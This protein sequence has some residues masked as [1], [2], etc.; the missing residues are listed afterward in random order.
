MLPMSHWWMPQACRPYARTI[1]S[2]DASPC[3]SSRR[4]SGPLRSKLDALGVGRPAGEEEVGGLPL[5][6]EA[7][8]QVLGALQQVERRAAVHRP[9]PD[10]RGEQRQGGQFQLRPGPPSAPPARP[11]AAAVRR[12]R[13]RTWPPRG[14]PRASARPRSGPDRRAGRPPTG[15]GRGARRRTRRP[16]SVRF[17]RVRDPQVQPGRPRAAAWSRRP[18]RGPGRARSGTRTGPRAWARAGRAPPAARGG[19]GRSGRRGRRRARAGRG[20]RRGR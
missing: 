10:D 1:G 16:A 9:H 5:P 18:T 11:T 12:P 8:G 13:A 7:A 14:G 20:R 2:A 6:T 19:R 15:D 4:A 17:E 3:S